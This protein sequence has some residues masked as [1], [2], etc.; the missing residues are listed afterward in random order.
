MK[1]PKPSMDEIARDLDS[2]NSALSH[3]PICS[4]S[5]NH[6]KFQAAANSILVT[7]QE[8]CL[9]AHRVEHYTNSIQINY[10]FI[11]QITFLQ[12]LPAPGKNSQ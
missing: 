7:Q 8:K 9:F 10:F 11:A 1:L 3:N 5:S 2:R 12:I 6:M 4:A